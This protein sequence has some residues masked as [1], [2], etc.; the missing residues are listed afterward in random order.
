MTLSSMP[1]TYWEV[2]R[3]GLDWLVNQNA[4]PPPSRSLVR[5]CSHILG[6]LALLERNVDKG[7]A[8]LGHLLSHTPQKQALAL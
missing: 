2:G 4:V 5:R 7:R 8:G 6:S 3:V 1:L